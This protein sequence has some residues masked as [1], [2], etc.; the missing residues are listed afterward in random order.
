MRS[1]DCICFG[2]ALVDF[3]PE[4]AGQPLSDVARFDR[5]LGGAPAN[6]AVG[7]QRNGV[8]TAMH[9]LVG[10]DAFGAFVL[11][12]LANEGIDVAAVGKHA[13]AKTGVAFVSV[14][15]DG[16][17]SFLFFR[18]P[19]ADMAIGPADVTPE[20][21]GRARLLHLG[22]STLSREPSRAATLRAVALAHE[23]G[24]PISIDPNLRAHL[25]HDLDEARALLRPILAIAEVVKISD[26]ELT[27][28][29]GISVGERSE[30]ELMAAAKEGATV[31]RALGCG[32][33]LVT[34]GDRG[35]WFDG[36]NGSGHVP[37]LAARVV[38]STGA[39]DAFVAGFLAS[40]MPALRA[41]QRPRSLAA[42][43]LRAAV[44][45][46]CV[47]GAE[48]VTR[49]GATTGVRHE[50]A[51]AQKGPMLVTAA[52]QPWTKL[53]EKL[54]LTTRI[55]EVRAQTLVSPRTGETRDFSVMSCPDWCNIVA[56]TDAGDVVM[57]RQVRHG[58]GEV[59]LELPGGMLDPEDPSA[60]HGAERELLEE[61]GYAGSN[62]KL[63]G[64]ISPNPA[65][66]RNR[67]HTAMVTG[68]RRVAAQTQDSGEDLQVVL[69]P[70]AEIPERIARGEISHSLVVVAFVWA[71]GLRPPAA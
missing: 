60:L 1:V 32:V 22:S 42:A 59:T 56:L 39:G 65:M 8:A 58:S 19:S 4:R 57:V 47:L 55:F 62:G 46:G 3:F 34:L 20:Q 9:T 66:Q 61:T 36:P 37:A 41:G 71:L 25:W 5:H 12:A 21:L 67:C 33:A 49:M 51:R 50:A 53:G 30:A 28:L 7:L 38:D 63:L 44:A 2:E 43:Q 13:S 27:P 68:A 18:H 31:L 24:L 17:R 10:P 26:D 11:A 52:P 14:A 48:A 15:G 64:V 69:V 35:A 6:V 29:L 23:A 40:V 16:A 70:Y 54:V 45:H